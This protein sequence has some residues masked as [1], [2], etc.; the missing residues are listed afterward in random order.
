MP[1][2]GGH[3]RS[4]EVP[5][6]TGLDQA[7]NHF[8][9]DPCGLNCFFGVAPLFVAIGVSERIGML[10]VLDQDLRE[11]CKPA[12][13]CKPQ[14]EIEILRKARNPHDIFRLS[15]QLRVASWR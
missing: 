4:F 11:V 12:Y 8:A 15:Q 1:I 13:F 14:E 7:I 9:P 3:P 2:Y 10:A 6:R 5:P